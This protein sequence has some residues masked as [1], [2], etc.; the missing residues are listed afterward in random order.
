VEPRQSRSLRWA[1][2]AFALASSACAP[3]TSVQRVIHGRTVE[4]PEVSED[5][6]AAYARGAYF[7]ARGQSA[8][9]IQAYREALD[10]G[11][12][13]PAAWTRL[14]AL[15]C[16][17]HARDAEAAF[18]S[19][20]GLDAGYAPAWSARAEC[21][22][23]RREL[24]AALADALRAV[25]LD[26]EDTAANL[27]VARVY[28]AQNRLADAKAWLFALV[29]QSPEVRAHWVALGAFAAASHDEALAG[30]SRAELV[31]RGAGAEVMTNAEGRGKPAP[32]ALSSELRNALDDDD[33]PRA[34]AIAT[35]EGIDA[36]TLGVLAASNGYPALADR[37][38][39]L[40]LEADPSDPDALIVA[41]AVAQAGG[42]TDRLRSLLQRAS[43]IGRPSP[44]GARLLGD[45]I[46]WLVDERAERDWLDA[47]AP[48][49][50]PPR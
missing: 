28:Q 17:E 11:S 33:L 29:L 12:A 31:R 7:E 50:S 8:A 36:R 3:S 30:Y 2:A 43:S 23:S 41:L 4:G 45:L 15:Y 49:P 18:E 10:S 48:R 38:A 39:T 20:I 34:R 22:Y 46:R 40:V 24:E 27:L 37:Q 13:N 19:A 26:A 16:R 42:A 14:G 35:D 5:A 1:L 44:L 32:A 21:R 9:A 6:Y 25:R 47:Y